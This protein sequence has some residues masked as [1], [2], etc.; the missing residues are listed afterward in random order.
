MGSQV[1]PDVLQ[2]GLRV[3]FCGTAAG[4]ESAAR[5]A[6]YAGRGN[7]FWEILRDTELTPTK[8]RPEQFERLREH[9][10]GLTDVCKTASGMDHEVSGTAFDPEQLRQT[11]AQVAPFAV[12]F[13]GK[14]AARTALGNKKGLTL[15][16]G[17]APVPVSLSG[18]QTWI[19]PSTS[20]AAVRWWDAKP[21]HDL[22]RSLL[23][24]DLEHSPAGETDGPPRG[25][26]DR[27]FRALG[28]MT[29]IAALS[30]KFLATRHSS[31]V[32][33]GNHSEDDQTI[34][35]PCDALVKGGLATARRHQTR[36]NQ[37]A[38]R[39]RQR[40]AFA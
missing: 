21:W 37:D 39:R 23:P 13:N 8:L 25:L 19:L 36:R 2:D 16:Y 12:A 24:L 6:Y 7:K 40:P 15:N 4:T 31:A 32:D 28:A 18:A 17:L 3:V 27:R 33:D 29:V 22:A 5:S 34:Y 11:I 10:I 26:K 9:G 30:V 35:Q 20:A 38:Y 14:R 1:L